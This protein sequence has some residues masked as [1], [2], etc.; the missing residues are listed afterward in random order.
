M[1][2]VKERPLLLCQW[3]LYRGLDVAVVALLLDR[4]I[5]NVTNDAAVVMW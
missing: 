3:P 2:G 5:G 4:V 1:E